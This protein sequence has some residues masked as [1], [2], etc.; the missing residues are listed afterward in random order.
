M[1]ADSPSR[2]E[3]DPRLDPSPGPSPAPAAPPAKS[4]PGQGRGKRSEFLVHH[5]KID[6]RLSAD[7]RAAY[8]ALMLDPRQ[9]MDSLLAW[10]HARGYTDISR[11]AVA[12][13]RR[14]FEK[15]VKDIRKTAK[16][17]C[18]FAALARAQG[19]AGS[20]ADA[21]Q[22]R[23]E[24]MFL[25]RL[26]GM[27]GDERLSGKEWSEFGKAMTA[28]LENR[29]KYETLR[30]EWEEKAA[31][32]ARAVMHRCSGRTEGQEIAEEVCE[33]LGIPVPRD[34]TS[35]GMGFSAPPASRAE[36]ENRTLLPPP[37]EN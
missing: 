35:N 25:E 15:D 20:L 21:G 19:G 3:S 9:T 5:F 29:Q 2:E 1:C 4:G 30:A 34:D 6:E 23:F 32:A 11:G 16:V 37:G 10:L 28:L 36:K 8:E 31:R 24:Q 26:F 18:Q 27:K 17:A 12:R 14:N 22:F 13:H 33:L 7:D